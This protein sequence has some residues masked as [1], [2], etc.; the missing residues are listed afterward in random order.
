MRAAVTTLVLLGVLLGASIGHAT[1]TQDLD[2]GRKSFKARDWES[3]FKTLNSLV[4][5]DLQLARQDDIVETYILLGASLY[6]LGNRDRA[7][8]EFTKALQLDRERS[9]TTLTYSEGVVRLFE[10]TKAKL[11]DKLEADAVRKQLAEREQRIKDYINTIGVYET[12]SFGVNFVG[13]GVGQFQNKQRTKGAILIGSQL[14]AG[15]LSLGCFVYLG[16]KY[17][18]VAKVPLEEG[19]FV[20]RVQQ[21]EIASGLAFFGL[22]AYSVI[23]ALVH[24]QPNARIKGDDS[25]LSPDILD[26]QKP[27]PKPKKKTSIRERLRFGPM[28]TPSGV[29]LGIGLEN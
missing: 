16:G 5:P 17:G 25:K 2:D 6:E 28:F 8:A 24:Y 19:P 27:L 12:H 1:P 7:V 4:Y 22:W 23:D 10:D 14:L 20:R 21:V 13:F 29:G 18:L 9:I 3:A 15:G 11:M 26:P